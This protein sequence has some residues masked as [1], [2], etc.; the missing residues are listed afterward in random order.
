[1]PAGGTLSIATRTVHL[2]DEG[3]N[4]VITLRPGEYVVLDV[5]D[6]GTGM[7]AQTLSHLF[8]PFFTT[9]EKGRGTGLGLSTSYGIVKQNHGE[10]VVRSHPGEGA[11]FSIY[12]PLVREPLDSTAIR[13]LESPNLAG[14]ETIL[15]A[16]DED[17]VRTVMTDMLRK[18]GYTVIPVPGGTE[19]LVIGSDLATKLDLLVTDIVMPQMGGRELADRLRGYR[20]GIKVLFV[21]GY[22]EGAIVQAGDLAPGTAFLQKPFSPE[23]LGLK[24]RELLEQELPV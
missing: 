3:P 13:E 7:D 20:P 6:T 15:V 21:S 5:T 19:A 14:K 2:D 17:G 9:K 18:Q 23:D 12:L 11:V 22:T 4:Q 1:M 8:E 24:V 16:E 10:I